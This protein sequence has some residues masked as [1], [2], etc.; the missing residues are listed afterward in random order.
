MLTGRSPQFADPLDEEPGLDRY[1]RA[2]ARH[3]QAHRPQ[4]RLGVNNRGPL[5]AAGIYQIIARRGRQSY[6]RA[7]HDK[8][9]RPGN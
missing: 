9:S 7:P 8:K 1:I 4:L 3:T 6:F 5:T 2:R